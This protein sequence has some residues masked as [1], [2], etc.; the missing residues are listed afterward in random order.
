MTSIMFRCQ[1]KEFERGQRVELISQKLN[2]EE[3]EQIRK[4][5]PGLT[6]KLD[7]CLANRT[8]II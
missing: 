1:Q 3:W 6:Y 7:S 4:S 8:V 5:H 2:Y